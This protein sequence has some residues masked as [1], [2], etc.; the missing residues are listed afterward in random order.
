VRPLLV[1]AVA[2]VLTLAPS[3]AHASPED[4]FGYGD[5]SPGMGATGPASADGFEATYAN[6]ALL[7]RLRERKLS[8][9]WQG[10]TFQLRATGAGL[11]G[12]VPYDAAKGIII[13]AAFPVP[14]G[15]ILK[16]RVGVGLA[17]YTPTQVLVRGDIEYPETPQF[18]LL[19]NRAQLL[20]IDFGLG[21][22]VGWGIRV[23]GGV[24]TV[25]ELTGSVVAATDSSGK[26]G[27]NVQDQL[28]AVYAPIVG[29]SYDLPVGKDRP[30]RIGATYR[31]ALEAS[32][33]VSLD[34]TKLTSLNVPLLNIGGIAQ[35]DPAQIAVEAAYDT[36]HLVVA[37]GATYKRWSQYPGPLEQ[38]ITC[39][40][41][42]PTCT[43]LTVA[44]VGYHDTVAVHVGADRPIPVTR[45]LVAHVRAGYFLEPTP[46]PSSLGSSSA[47]SAASASIVAVPTR[48]FDATRH[49]ITLG[50]GLDLGSKGTF[51]IDVFGQ[52]HLLQPRTMTFTSGST[53]ESLTTSTADVGG[54]VLM[55][56]MV[57][58]VK[59]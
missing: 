20:A 26:V 44:H 12:N 11:P 28:I 18:S 7:S 31:G 46:L 47:Y 25:A 8:L 19:P 54:H 4:I 21:V 36:R 37:L 17:F 9:G 6:P 14:F 38:T 41:S 32:F 1:S 2:A 3:L 13:G 10:A 52:L 5:R 59:F 55:A 58:G 51:T 16:D 27:T 42:D 56:G 23:G 48:Y 53:P 30:W 57:L 15:G 22:D 33:L 40:A 35:Y 49:A 45:V 50:G 34:A 24:S 39:P 29:A 43:A